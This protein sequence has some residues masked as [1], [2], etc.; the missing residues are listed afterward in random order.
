MCYKCLII[1]LMFGIAQL[2]SA[3]VEK[4]SFD[5]ATSVQIKA[6]LGETAPSI[7]FPSPAPRPVVEVYGETDDGKIVKLAPVAK[8]RNADSISDGKRYTWVPG[9]N[10]AVLKMTC[11]GT[12]GDN[13]YTWQLRL[14]APINMPERAGH[15]HAISNQPA[16]TPVY[17]VPDIRKGAEYYIDDVLWKPQF[18]YL[19]EALTPVLGPRSVV[20]LSVIDPKYS[21][22]IALPLQYSGAGACQGAE[23][24]YLDILV[25]DLVALPAGADYILTGSIKGQHIENHYGTV[26]TIEALK[27][28]ATQWHSTHPHSNELAFN[29]ISLP[30]GGAFDVYD[31]WISSHSH[32]NHSFGV[33]ADVSKGCVKKSDRSDLISLMYKLGFTV[34]SEGDPTV[35]PSG[36]VVPGS[37]ANHYH[38]QYQPEINRLMKTA[39]PQSADILYPIKEDGMMKGVDV[40]IEQADNGRWVFGDMPATRNTKNCEK[41]MNSVNDCKNPVVGSS[42]YYYCDCIELFYDL[43]PTAENPNIEPVG[44]EGCPKKAQ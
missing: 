9:L 2:A 8:T 25:P 22:S 19:G 29:D 6:F 10:H 1:G 24:R 26:A 3:G 38:I 12:G 36:N 21:T 37:K 11:E 31:D 5:S 14:M 32:F 4:T 16:G 28:L 43:Q 17:P 27:K 39:I 42:E 34:L 23:T 7:P 35:L 13:N 15:N 20:K 33:A 44:Y 30:W 40:D 41:Y 18:N